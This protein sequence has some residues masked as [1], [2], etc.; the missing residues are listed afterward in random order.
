[1]KPSAHWIDVLNR[2]G[3]PCGPVLG[4]E[5]VFE[6]P[7]VRHQGMAT[8]Y[9]Q[10]GAG[11]VTVLSLPVNFTEEPFRIR[12]PAP[13]LGEHTAEVLDE[14]GIAPETQ[15]RLRRAGVL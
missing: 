9:E 5:Q 1:E 4:V 6:D 11:S 10:P 15:E 2:A 8:T 12:R 7:Q 13:A 3:V 14:L